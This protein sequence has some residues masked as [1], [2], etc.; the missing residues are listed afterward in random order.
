MVT[1]EAPGVRCFH[2]LASQEFFVAFGRSMNQKHR[3]MLSLK[4]FEAL[5]KKRHSNN[6]Y[7]SVVAL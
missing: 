4:A 3:M 5:Y 6:I 1:F 2:L 7:V